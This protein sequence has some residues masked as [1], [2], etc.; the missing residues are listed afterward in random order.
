VR[1]T[2]QN[3]D[4]TVKRNDQVDRQVQ[5]HIKYIEKRIIKWKALSIEEQ[6]YEILKEHH[7]YRN[8]NTR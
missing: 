8:S 3:L 2:S 4:E 1:I 7:A 5:E 6:A